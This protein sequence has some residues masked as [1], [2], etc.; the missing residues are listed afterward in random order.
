[1]KIV[2]GRFPATADRATIGAGRAGD[3][4]ETIQR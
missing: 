4:F 2:N 1:M 3:P